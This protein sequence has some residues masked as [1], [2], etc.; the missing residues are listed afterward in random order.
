MP[1]GSGQQLGEGSFLDK[2]LQFR[3]F[4]C[5]TVRNCRT[6]SQYFIIRDRYTEPRGRGTLKGVERDDITHLH[7]NLGRR[8][9]KHLALSRVLGIVDS[10]EGIGE[11]HFGGDYIDAQFSLQ[12]PRAWR[13]PTST[14]R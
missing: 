6:V 12:R 14:A 10:V 3:T 7:N 4:F 1:N 5:I 13:V 8:V 2:I 9:D 11:T